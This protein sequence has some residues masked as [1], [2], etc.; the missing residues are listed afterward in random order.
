MQE[1]KGL[2]NSTIGL[3]VAVAL[4]FDTIQALLT[5]IA[6]GYFVPLI[7]Y[8]TF[9][10]WFRLHGLSF[11][12]MKRAP[13]LGI[14]ALLEIIPGIDV[15]PAFTFTVIRVALDSRFKPASTDAIIDR[16]RA[17]STKPKDV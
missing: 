11:F 14:G 17:R 7:S 12:T 8:P 1:N 6:I 3:M 10:L 9:W 13:T 15:I 4:F 2:S 16:V 5:P